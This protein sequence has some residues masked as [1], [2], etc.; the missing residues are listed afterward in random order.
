MQNNITSYNWHISLFCFSGAALYVI[1][2]CRQNKDM[3]STWRDIRECTNT[4]VQCVG[5][6]S[7]GLKLSKNTWHHTQIKITSD[8]T[9]AIRLSDII[10]S[11]KTMKNPCI[12]HW[13]CEAVKWRRGF[14]VVNAEL[15]VTFFFHVKC[16]KIFFSYHL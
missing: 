1:K 10:L 14:G 11:W 5:K 4:H 16:G 15:T 8:V 13:L 6:D 12:L 9:S 7:L 2:L 3:I